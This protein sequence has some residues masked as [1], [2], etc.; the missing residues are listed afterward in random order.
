MSTHVPVLLQ[1]VIEYLNPTPNQVFIDGTV[2]QGGHAEVLLERIL[3]RGRL[4]GIDR[5]PESLGVAKKRLSSSQD[6]VVLVHDSYANVTSH[7]YVHQ[8]TAVNGILLDL[9]FASH[10]VDV[11]S[12]GFTF[13]EDGPLDMRFDQTQ[14]LDARAIVNEWSEDE[15]AR[16]F[17]VYGEEKKA[18]EIAQAIVRTRKTDPI[19]RTTQ[20]A[21]V[22]ESV[23]KR[24]G[25]IHPATKVFQAIRIAVNTELDELER[26]LPD[27]VELLAPSGRIAIITFHSLEDRVVKQF[28]AQRDDLKLVNKKVITPSQEEI[29]AN[30][31]ARSA[32][33]RVAEKI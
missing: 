6:R 1:E 18:R 15:L 4:L 12:R 10:H 32:K 25:K 30:P 19:E 2:G 27:F 3:P 13:K 11:A 9:G 29:K 16:I 22:V 20:L 31:R 17:R 21:D 8:F 24:R 23:V 7:A 33:L 5:D 28:F 14:A 26:A